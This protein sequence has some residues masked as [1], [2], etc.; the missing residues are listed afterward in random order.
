VVGQRELRER[1]GGAGREAEVESADVE[2]QGMGAG[3]GSHPLSPWHGT[4]RKPAA[5]PASSCCCSNVVL[6]ITEG[7]VSLC[8]WDLLLIKRSAWAIDVGSSGGF[9][10]G[11]R[12]FLFVAGS[13]E[14]EHT[15]WFA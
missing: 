14:T 1:H 3:G 12:G 5:E 4:L 9:P 10:R 7:Q 8:C 2:A 11:A 15:V 6:V 13:A